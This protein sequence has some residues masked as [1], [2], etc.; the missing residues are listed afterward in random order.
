MPS[1]VNKSASASS[2]SSQCSRRRLSLPATDPLHR[3]FD[4]MTQPDYTDLPK[5]AQLRRNF[6]LT[7]RRRSSLLRGLY[8]RNS[9]KPV[10]GRCSSRPNSV[11]L[12][13]KENRLPEQ[14]S[15]DSNLDSAD[16]D[17]C[18]QLNTTE[19]EKENA[20]LRLALKSCLAKRRGSAPSNLIL[21]DSLS[22]SNSNILGHNNQNSPNML[23]Q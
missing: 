21:G 8:N 20:F 5:T 9:L 3:I 16:L 10:R 13:S 15:M 18:G 14:S 23:L 11:C 1:L 17:L 4:Q 2:S 7:D 19:L 6:S 22:S 12:Q